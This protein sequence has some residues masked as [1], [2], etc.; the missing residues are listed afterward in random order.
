MFWH[1][2][3]QKL[4]SISLTLSTLSVYLFQ[5]PA[6]LYA[7]KQLAE[8]AFS[9][10][11]K[12]NTYAEGYHTSNPFCPIWPIELGKIMICCSLMLSLHFL[13]FIWICYWL[14]KWHR[15]NIQGHWFLDSVLVIDRTVCALKEAVISEDQFV[16]SSLSNR[17]S[18]VNRTRR[19]WFQPSIPCRGK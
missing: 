17:L 8:T 2:L 6:W 9:S 19:I 5:F 11:N 13:T 12:S 14:W 18:K 10:I 7:A 3:L 16:V 4:H 1:F 15:L